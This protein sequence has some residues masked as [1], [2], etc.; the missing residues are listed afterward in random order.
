M[1]TR[2]LSEIKR[3]WSCVRIMAVRKDLQARAIIIKNK[4]RYGGSSRSHRYFSVDV[5]VFRGTPP[6]K[7]LIF[8]IRYSIVGAANGL[9]RA[10]HVGCRPKPAFAKIKLSPG[11]II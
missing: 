1:L 3:A 4:H 11:D 8:K 7:P 9:P 6:P 5:L 10:H 2:S